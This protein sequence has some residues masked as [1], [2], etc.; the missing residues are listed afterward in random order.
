MNQGLEEIIL[1]KEEADLEAGQSPSVLLHNK[2]TDGEESPRTPSVSSNEGKLPVALLDWESPEDP[3]NPKNWP[4]WKRIY[5]TAIPALY[6]FVITVGTS[7][8][9]PAIPFIMAKFQVERTIAVL[10]LSLYTLGF[11]VGPVLAA[12]LSELYGRRIVY[13]TSLP[14]L[15]VFIA[16]AGTSN[17]ITEL[18]IT[19]FIG[20]VCGSGALAV[21]AGT[22][23]D[24][25]SPQAAG[26]AAVFYILSPFL[27]PALGPLIGAYIIH[28]Y[29][30]NWRWSQWV[31]IIIAGPMLILAAFMKETSKVQILH[32]RHKAN[33][34]QKP[35][36][37]AG[38]TRI[39]LRK[40]RLAITR[41]M[42][43][44]LFEP[45]VALLSLYTG[46]AFAM[47]FSFF[48]SYSYV[49]QKIYH[50]NSRE[51]GLTFLGILVGFLFAVGTFGVFDATIFR[52]EMVK[53]AAK[54]E[55]PA[56]EHRLYTAMFG[57]V[58]LPIGLFWFAY[59]PRENVHW[60]VP[61][62][63]GVPFGWGCLG[64]FVS[65]TT[66]LVDVYQA[67]NG[68]SAV[69]ANGI[70]RYL[71]GAIFPLFTIQMY[72]AMGVHN[73]GVVFA[74]VALALT[75]L[76]WWFY[77]KGEALRKRSTYKQ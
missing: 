22:I 57:S 26:R 25:W 7:S 45:T 41:P 53:A 73:A 16:I 46:F 30:D 6:G 58:M 49:F 48:G 42:H 67:A 59:A 23:A 38:D 37:Q 69:A 71:F 63:A 10:P 1:E 65:V 77:W 40:L 35:A 68:A 50:F 64:I 15:V 61:L 76:P 27:G 62:L 44:M 32:L 47:M 72:E 36:H 66:Y 5:H 19:R 12:P 3:G 39:L 2:E 33:G 74:A 70:L 31:A 24:L 55:R 20:A 54:G 43:M 51:V 21:G 56:P 11:T 4:R 75:P 60:I 34:Y 17:D 18:I 13:W 29:N 28:Q 52:K 8:Y 14:L 9:V